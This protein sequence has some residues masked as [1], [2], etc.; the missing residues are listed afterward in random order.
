MPTPLWGIANKAAQSKTYRFQNLISL[1]TV[2]WLLHCWRFVNKKAAAGV[3]RQSA[4]QYA[5][6]L[7]SN[8][9]DLADS[10]QGRWYR[11]KL[12]LRKYIPKLNGKLRPLGD[13]RPLPTSC[14]KQRWRKYS[15][16]STSRIYC[17]VA[18]G[19]GRGRER[20][21]QLKSCRRYSEVESIRSSS[22]LI[23]RASSITS[24]MICSWIC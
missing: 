1:L 13:S 21:R 3:D 5:Q 9:A 19:I 2:E 18:L 7:D 12:V 15:K 11:A 20:I 16:R 6:N 17:L 8:A 10:V 24:I 22:K 14:C 4:S 23:L